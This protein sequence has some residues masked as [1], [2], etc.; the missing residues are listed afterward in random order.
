MKRSYVPPELLIKL[1]VPLCILCTSGLICEEEY[2][3]EE[4]DIEF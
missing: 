2:P 1:N 3:G 4:K